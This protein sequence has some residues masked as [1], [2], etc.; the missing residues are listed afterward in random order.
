MSAI[1]NIIN[2]YKK[3]IILIASFFVPVFLL[4]LVYKYANIYPFGKFSLLIMDL[5]AQYIDFMIYLKHA[6][7][8]GSSLIYSWTK[9]GGAPLLDLFFYYTASPLNLILL[10]FEDDKI[11]IIS[12]TENDFKQTNTSMNDTLG[13]IVK[14]IDITGFF[15]PL[16][17]FP[18]V[19][20]TYILNNF[21]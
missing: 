8:D 2:R 15:R 4:L 6:I 14:V 16:G 17:L 12:F 19:A 18:L 10:F 21:V 3:T 1:L 9:A 5:D 20:G 7:T 11:A 13:T